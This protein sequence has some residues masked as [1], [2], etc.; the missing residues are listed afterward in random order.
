MS[1]TNSRVGVRRTPARWKNVSTPSTRPRARRTALVISSRPT[2]SGSSDGCGR[3]SSWSFDVTPA[4][5]PLSRWSLSRRSRR[6][7]TWAVAICT[8]APSRWT[9]TAAPSAS[10]GTTIRTTARSV[11]STSSDRASRNET[12]ASTASAASRL[13][14]SAWSAIRSS[15]AITTSATWPSAPATSSSAGV[16]ARP[17]SISALSPAA[18]RNEAATTAVPPT[19]RTRAPSPG[20]ND[21]SSSTPST[22]TFA[23]PTSRVASRA[24]RATHGATSSASPA[25]PLVT[26]WSWSAQ[27]TTSTS[28]PGP[29]RAPS[30]PRTC[31]SSRS[32]R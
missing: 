13:S 8:S 1:R 10:A 31:G 9:C 7:S 23:C 20:A 6:A 5:R 18:A 30:T 4:H 19:S 3:F 16:C 14:S 24:D 27:R 22:A 25:G 29:M 26:P 12:S 15:A 11:S 28:P 21:D 17:R 2:S 32:P